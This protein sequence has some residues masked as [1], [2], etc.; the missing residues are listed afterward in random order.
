MSKISIFKKRI[1]VITSLLLAISLSFTAIYAATTRKL[2]TK[3]ASGSFWV[4]NCM[5]YSFKASAGLTYNGSTISSIS[6]LSFSGKTCTSTVPGSTCTIIPTQKS[7]TY[8]GNTA[9]YVVTITRNAAGV[10][11]DK[12]DYTFTYKTTDSGTPYSL[13]RPDDSKGVL[14]SVEVGNPYDIRSNLSVD[15]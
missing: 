1:L 2:I 8:S 7:K 15:D 6:D 13:E 3:S 14:V 9:K 4:N 10:Y 12:V 11:S 5:K